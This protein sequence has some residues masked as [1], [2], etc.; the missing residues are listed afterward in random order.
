MPKKNQWY[1]ELLVDESVQDASIFHELLCHLGKVIG[2]I[3]T[4]VYIGLKINIELL[5]YLI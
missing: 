1:E 5:Q 2:K 3:S 4:P